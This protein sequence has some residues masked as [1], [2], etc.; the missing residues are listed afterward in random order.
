M[1]SSV[2]RGIVTTHLGG[3]VGGDDAEQKLLLLLALT[4]ELDS[5]LDYGLC[6]GESLP[7]SS[8][9]EDPI[10]EARRQSRQHEQHVALH[11]QGHKLR[12]V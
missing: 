5:R 4:L 1:R 2:S 12:P 11:L 7:V 6:A 3:D 9:G 8:G 10:V